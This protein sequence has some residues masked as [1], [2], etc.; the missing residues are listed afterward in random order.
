MANEVRKTLAGLDVESLNLQKE[1]RAADYLAIVCWLLASSLAVQKLP[2][3]CI[4][5]SMHN[6]CSLRDTANSPRQLLLHYSQ[7]AHLNWPCD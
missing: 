2:R 4:P 5:A 1:K 3:W 7:L 6:Y